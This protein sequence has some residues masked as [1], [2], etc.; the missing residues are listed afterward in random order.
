MLPDV[1]KKTSVR[2]RIFLLILLIVSTN[3]IDRASLSVAMPT[4]GREFG[5]GPTMQGVIF[6]S[7]FWSY[8]LM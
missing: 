1:A 3:Y 7:F 8:A 2:W 5:I 6:S 4:I